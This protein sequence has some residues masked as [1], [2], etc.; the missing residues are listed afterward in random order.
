MSFQDVVLQFGYELPKKNTEMSTNK[1]QQNRGKSTTIFE[2]NTIEMG[3][4]KRYIG[5]YVVSSTEFCSVSEV[6]NG[7]HCNQ[8]LDPIYLDHGSPVG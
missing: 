8:F 3:F 4:W 6:P 5:F 7:R 2:E 1:I